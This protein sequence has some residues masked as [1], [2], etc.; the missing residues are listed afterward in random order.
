V[1]LY[2]FAIIVQAKVSYK[3]GD[4]YIIEYCNAIARYL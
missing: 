4:N 2:I 1:I 3:H